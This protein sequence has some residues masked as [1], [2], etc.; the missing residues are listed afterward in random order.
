MKVIKE[1]R[2]KTYKITCTGC[3]SD[4]E[5]T[6]ADIKYTIE[7]HP[8]LITKTVEHWFKPWEHYRGIEN[9]E[10]ANIKCPVCGRNI[11][12]SSRRPYDQTI[13]RWEKE[14]K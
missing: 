14:D 8:S 12:M 2:E 13:I 6:D 4:L 3:N 7:E 10:F 5:Y 9:K 1:G 11:K